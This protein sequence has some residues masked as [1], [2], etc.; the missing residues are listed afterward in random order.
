MEIKQNEVTFPTLSRKMRECKK[1]P[2]IKRGSGVDLKSA[3]AKRPACRLR[4]GDW[5]E[6]F[7][8]RQEGRGVGAKLIEVKPR[9]PGTSTSGRNYAQAAAS[10]LCQAHGVSLRHEDVLASG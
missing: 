4:K 10:P 7:S 8:L 2:V 5:L 3:T 6:P 9:S 1:S